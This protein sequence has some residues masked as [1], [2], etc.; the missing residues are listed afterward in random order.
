MEIKMHGLRKRKKPTAKELM[1]ENTNLKI[2]AN[3]RIDAVSGIANDLLFETGQDLASAE[4]MVNMLKDL[5]W[6]VAKKEIYP[7]ELK[8]WL[9]NFEA[10]ESFEGTN[11]E[12]AE[13]LGLGNLKRDYT[14]IYMSIEKRIAKRMLDLD[15]G[16][17]LNKSY[18]RIA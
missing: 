18:E 4:C 10:Q 5:V 1:E 12:L 16:K 11:E 3:K 9:E 7:H 6:Q 15:T 17:M 2:E 13:S 14:E 8:R